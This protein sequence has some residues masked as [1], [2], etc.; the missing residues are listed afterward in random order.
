MKKTIRIESIRK[1]KRVLKE[2]NDLP[3]DDIEWTYQ[4]QPITV[5]APTVT[6][7]KN[8]D[9]IDLAQGSAPLQIEYVQQQI[10]ALPSEDRKM[11]SDEHHTFDELYSYR[12]AYNALLFNSWAKQGLYDV[13]KSWR[14]SDGNP[15]FGGG[16]F[17]VVATTP[18]GQ[19]SNHYKSEFWDLFAVPVV[20]LSPEYDG[21]TP[22]QALDRLMKSARMG[23]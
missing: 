23:A 3:L 19:V 15:C 6:G 9:L 20:E 18:F 4:G 2:A 13:Q 10:L 12:M 1:A 21:H 17:I 22:E 5:V 11:L 7:M 14:H 8:T 16:W